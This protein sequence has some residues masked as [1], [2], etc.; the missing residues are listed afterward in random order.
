M[1]CHSLVFVPL[2]LVLVAEQMILAHSASLTP[3]FFLA[4]HR[5]RNSTGMDPFCQ[6]QIYKLASSGLCSGVA[7]QVMTS[8][9]V[10][11]PKEGDASFANHTSEESNIFDSLAARAT[12]MVEG[13][14]AIDGIECEPAEG[15]MYCSSLFLLLLFLSSAWFYLVFV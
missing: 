2:V 4:C 12:M 8:L 9:M 5:L 1:A 7:G 10:N 3:H 14:N 13:L 15:A 6:A 11:P